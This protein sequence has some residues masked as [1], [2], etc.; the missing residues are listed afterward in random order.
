MS[1]TADKVRVPLSEVRA[2]ATRRGFQVGRRGHISEAIIARFN[3]AH[4]TKFAESKNPMGVTH[5]S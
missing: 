4:P 3:R 5:G 1:A 2:W